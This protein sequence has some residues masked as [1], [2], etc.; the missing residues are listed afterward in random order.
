M[1]VYERNKTWWA[2]F[3]I[4]GTR[5]RISL[6]VPVAKVSEARAEKIALKKYAAAEHGKLPAK[7][8][9]S[10]ARLNFKEAADKDLKSTPARKPESR[11]QNLQLLKKL[12]CW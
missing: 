6:D 10:F 7:R 5:F 4:D 3:S 1:K 11:E 12:S 9:R 8:S 2:D